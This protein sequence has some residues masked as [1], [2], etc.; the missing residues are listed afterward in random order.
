[1]PYKKIIFIFLLFE[2]FN[3]TRGNAV[4]IL[5]L[6]ADQSIRGKLHDGKNP[7]IIRLAMIKITALYHAVLA[8]TGR[9]DIEVDK[10][11]LVFVFFRLGVHLALVYLFSTRIHIAFVIPAKAEIY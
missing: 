7:D 6:A 11:A 10:K 2:G 1:V 8:F 4:R 9:A 3:R 5:A